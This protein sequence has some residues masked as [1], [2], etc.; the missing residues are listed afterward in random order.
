M[1]RNYFKTAWRN[2]FCNKVNSTINII[3]LSLGIAICLLI[4][5]YVK[6]ELSY[7]RYHEKADRI[8]RLTT[9]FIIQDF[10]MH[11]ARGGIDVAP[12]LQ[13]TYP[14]LEKAVRLKPLQTAILKKGNELFT[15]KDIFMADK[16]IFSLFSFPM[17]S[18]NAA[19]ALERPNSIV[20]TRDLAQKYFGD[21]N[22]LGKIIFFNNKPFTI[23]AVLENLPS[24]TDLKFKALICWNPTK[25]EEADWTDISYFTYLLFRNKKDIAG[26]ENKLKA[27]DER[28][29]APRGKLIGETNLSMTHYLQPLKQL[30][31]EP[32]LIDDTPKGNRSY[33]YIFSAVAL[34]ILFVACINFIN[35]YLA[36]ISKRQKE[37]GIRKVSG[38]TKT[39]LLFQFLGES[40]LMTL[41]AI[42]IAFCILQLIAPV[43]NNLTGKN[44]SLMNLDWLFTSVAIG[45][46]ILVGLL[47]GSYPAI[48]LSSLQPASILKG[49]SAITGK[50]NFRKILLVSQFT[51]SIIL[52]ICTLI[53]FQQINFMKDKNPGFNKDQV[54]AIN[55]PFDSTVRSRLPLLKSS[56][57]ENP[58][59]SNV[60]IA[61]KPIG[62]DSK[63][64]FIKQSN[65]KKENLMISFISID[66]QYL[67]VLKIPIVTGRNFSASFPTDKTKGVIVNET[68]V[69]WMGWKNPIGQK[70]YPSERP[71]DIHNVIG[72]VKDFH[73]IS[74]HDKIE[75][76]LLYNDYDPTSM[77]IETKLKN[78]SV[79]HS[80]WKK[81][82][83][84]YPFDYSFFDEAIGKQYETEEKMV[85]IFTTFA[86]LTILIACLG[87]FGLI[88]IVVIQRTKEIGIRKVFGASVNN[89]VGLLS[90]DFLLLVV[91]AAFIAYPIAWLVIQKWLQNF[92]YRIQI[93]LWVFILAGGIAVSVALLTVSFQAIKAAV[94]NPVKSLR[95]E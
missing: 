41:I 53:A 33:L 76:L 37:V 44:F 1:I 36:Q 73:Y 81:L 14:E 30:H 85:T 13:Q 52:I 92:P 56:L 43:F 47:S 7:D 67:P 12:I 95:S 25:E 57:M 35:L 9:K 2:I 58:A 83:P 28:E 48:Y 16:E 6:D 32:A 5:F 90:K 3:G 74:M 40:F 61:P 11:F 8:C 84:D 23:T 26:F 94:A 20:L 38:A 63:A 50:S 75:P 82:F 51:I 86:I 18:G 69:K 66:E 72:V 24:N 60:S 31:F 93:N 45:V 10:N 4:A 78:I 88:S 34:C 17:L 42:G 79:V 89:I 49:K 55:I 65:G 77:L 59:I 29:F 80:Y 19:K 70:V 39:Q 22:P 21:N 87:L 68:M 64:S 27:F 91:V 71:E 15:E 62:I 46:L 54:I